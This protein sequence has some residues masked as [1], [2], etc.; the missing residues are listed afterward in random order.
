MRT[1]CDRDAHTSTLAHA[2]C[3]A[4][5][6]AAPYTSSS[7]TGTRRGALPVKKRKCGNRLPASVTGKHTIMSQTGA[8]AFLF[9]GENESTQNAHA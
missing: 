3:L 2:A 6:E 8:R 1:A 7:L 4:S 5:C 9:A